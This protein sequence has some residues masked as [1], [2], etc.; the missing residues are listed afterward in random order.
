MAM[1]AKGRA[2]SAIGT[3]INRGIEVGVLTY[4]NTILYC[5]VCGTAN[6]AM[7][8]N[9]SLD[10]NLTFAVQHFSVDGISNRFLDKTQ[11]TCRY[12]STNSNTRSLKKGSAIHRRYGSF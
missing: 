11:L 4:P 7:G 12:S 10:F 1:F 5:S 3:H 8:A 9:G 2:L 6:G